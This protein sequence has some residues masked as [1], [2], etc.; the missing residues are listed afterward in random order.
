MTTSVITGQEISEDNPYRNVAS[1]T[2]FSNPYEA[3]M[4]SPA[5]RQE[6]YVAEHLQKMT[7]RADSEDPGWTWEDT[8][9]VAR[10]FVDGLWL[11]K[12]DEVG[13]HLSATAFKM[14]NPELAQGK[15]ISEIAKE[16]QTSLE[17]EAAAFAEKRPMTQLGANIAGSIVSPVSLKGGQLL[18]KANQ[19]R[20]GRHAAQ[21]GDEVAVALGTGTKSDELA[22]MSAMYGQQQS[23]RLASQLSRAPTPVAASG[24]AAGEGAVIG[25]E[26]DDFKDKAINSTFTAGI[27]ATV[28]FAFAGAKKSFDFATET[29]VGQQ[30]GSGADF[31]NLMFTEHGLSQWYRSV[32]SK[33]YGARTLS[34]QQARKLVARVPTAKAARDTANALKDEAKVKVERA[35]GTINRNKESTI[36]SAKVNVDEEIARV[37]DD[38][39]NATGD[40]RGKYE[41][42]LIDLESMKNDDSILRAETVR[43]ADEAINAAE[44]TFR[45]QVMNA[46]VPSGTTADEIA[47]LGS[48]DPQDA[49]AFLDDLWKRKGFTFAHGKQYVVDP[50]DAESFIE[51][52]AK[53][54]PELSLVEGGGIV[55]RVT[56]YVNDVLQDAAP[57]GSIKGEDLVQLRSTI[58]RAINSLSD[59]KTSTRRFSAEVQDYFNDLLKTKLSADELKA[60]N[61]DKTAWGVRSLVDD[62]IAKASGGDA[63]G[64]AFTAKDFLD[65]TRSYSPRFAARGSGRF[66]K[67]AQ[68]LAQL[69]K[70]NKDNIV[71]LA[72]R[73]LRDIAKDTLQEKKALQRS[74]QNTRASLRKQQSEEISAINN[75]YKDLK[76]TEQVKADRAEKIAT[77]RQK[78]QLQQKDVDQKIDKVLAD[79]KSLANLMPSSFQGSVFENLFNTA[80][81]GQVIAPASG[82]IKATLTTGLVGA[83]ILARESTQR[84]LA[85]QTGAQ[86]SARKLAERLGNASPIPTGAG[87]L[88]SGVAAGATTAEGLAP[89]GRLFS[90]ER[91][92]IVRNMPVPGK[93]NLYRTLR[94]NGNLDR[95]EAEDPKLLQEL[96]KAFESRN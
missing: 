89:T 2:G 77:A 40:A 69:S 23:G 21:A 25:F 74:L 68:E 12:A 61:A 73:S 14:F 16:M 71:A 75:R 49:N 57:T 10:A 82:S 32:V 37:K 7:E 5:S 33:A 55:G 52:V 92:K 30:I 48:L 22:R 8:E 20:Q 9:M 84:I 31:V 18:A 11:N 78:H 76:L 66:Q 35:K 93:A 46:S 47:A 95:L 65:A 96:K 85:R 24:L 26:G 44:G 53:N 86:Q 36:A 39:A 42:R 6:Q 81:I 1:G 64:G 4:L 51:D 67:D 70:Q 29:K 56:Q 38:I 94:D 13:S 27:S 79:I 41:E 62:S 15:T 91:K 80:L 88:A 63:R 59:D 17:A 58:G 87:Q 28:P 34:E 90:E 50:E 83:N 60:F 19:L 54:Y 72:D 3:E 43:Q 45:G